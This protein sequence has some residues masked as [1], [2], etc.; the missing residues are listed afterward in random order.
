MLCF[1]IVSSWSQA[2]HHPQKD[3]HALSRSD[4]ME[5]S[6]ILDS[7]SSSILLHL[8]HSIFN[9]SVTTIP[10]CRFSPLPQYW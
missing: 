2:G 9:S 5:G 8:F 7:G 10:Q 1:P 3:L 4:K 6:Y